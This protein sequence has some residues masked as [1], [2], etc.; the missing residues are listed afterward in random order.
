MWMVK[1]WEAAGLA[2][3]CVGGVAGAGAR[4]AR[5]KGGGGRG[6]G[7]REFRGDEVG[8]RATDI[9]VSAVR[10]EVITQSQALDYLDI[11]SSD[12]ERLAAAVNR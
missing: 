11:P 8:A 5:G 3:P 12:F 1:R 6:R 7:G 10:R 9:F 2:A 4:G